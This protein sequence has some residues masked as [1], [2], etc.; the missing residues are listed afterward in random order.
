MVAPVARR[1]KKS[2]LKEH[3]GLGGSKVPSVSIFIQTMTNINNVEQHDSLG[4][5]SRPR[6]NA[7]A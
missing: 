1:V 3:G 4:F 6:H 7:A 5:A 2:K